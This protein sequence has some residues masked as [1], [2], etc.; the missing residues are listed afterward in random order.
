MT[1]PIKSLGG[2]GQGEVVFFWRIGRSGGWHE[3]ATCQWTFCAKEMRD[4]CKESSESLD[5]P[6]S[7]CSDCQ[8][9]SSGGIVTAAKPFSHSG[10]AMTI[11]KK[12]VVRNTKEKERERRAILSCAGWPVSFEILVR[13]EGGACIF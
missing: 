11:K 6:R 12:D 10:R 7:L 9:S 8:R 1:S 4:V 5:S 2:T 3:V 13:T